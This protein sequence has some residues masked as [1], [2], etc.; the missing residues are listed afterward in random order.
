MPHCV[1]CHFLVSFPPTIH[2]GLPL[3]WLLWKGRY[4]GSVILFGSF[5]SVPC[6]SN[7]VS[8][9]FCWVRAW[10]GLSSSCQP[11]GLHPVQT[12]LEP[13]LANGGA[14]PQPPDST[15]HVLYPLILT[16][17]LVCR[18]AVDTHLCPLT[19]K[20]L[21]LGLPSLHASTFTLFC[22]S[23][24][25]VHCQK[26]AKSC[27]PDP[28]LPRSSQTQAPNLAA[29]PCCLLSKGCLGEEQ[30]PGHLSSGTLRNQDISTLAS[31]QN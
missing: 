10:R 7:V 19:K 4:E 23:F 9:W 29:V 28:F 1:V 6:L 26:T 8:C 18:I 5:C 2:L 25:N 12:C 11:P 14:R 20:Q 3:L 16:S 30:K 15:K 24:W 31:A 13:Y 22:A 17:T 21:F 27:S